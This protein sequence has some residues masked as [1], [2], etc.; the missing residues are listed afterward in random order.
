MCIATA[1]YQEAQ[2]RRDQK[3]REIRQQK[4]AERAAMRAR[5]AAMTPAERSDALRQATEGFADAC[6]RMGDL[7]RTMRERAEEKRRA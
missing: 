4:D 5:F 6:R 3:L 1:A 2:A 7:A